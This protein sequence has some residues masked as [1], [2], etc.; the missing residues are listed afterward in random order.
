MEHASYLCDLSFYSSS[1]AGDSVV[2]ADKMGGIHMLVPGGG[3]VSVDHFKKDVKFYPADDLCFTTADMFKGLRVWD[4]SRGEVVYS[5]KEDSLQMHAYGARGCLGAV[6]EGCVKLYDL[7][8]RYNV[9]AVP[10]RMCRKVEWSGERI[11]CVGEGYVAEYDARCMGS[12]EKNAGRLR[13]KEVEG[14]LDV[15]SVWKG[16]FCTTRKDGTTYLVR[17]DGVDAQEGTRR[18]CVGGKLM[19]VGETSD[20]FVIGALGDNTV[21]FYEYKD[22]WT[23]VFSGAGHVDWVLFGEGNS[24]VFADRKV[25]LME[26][27]YDRFKGLARRDEEGRE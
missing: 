25:Y 22:T 16:E 4:R 24:Y 6:G 26:G 27:G 17:L 13:V 14:V 2:A 7:R 11:Y 15:V 10:L 21:G 3:V 8:V 18:P 9:G 23:H 1:M 12:N 5:Y 19:K 20:G